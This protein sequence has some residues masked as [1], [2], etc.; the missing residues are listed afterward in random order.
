MSVQEKLERACWQDELW[1]DPK[2]DSK[3]PTKRE[4]FSFVTPITGLSRPSTGKEDDDDDD[5]DD[6]ELWLKGVNRYE[7][8]EFR[9]LHSSVLFDALQD[10]MPSE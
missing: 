9:Q 3:I 7:P 8:A 4:G 2:N 6:D 10:K 5:D 1:H